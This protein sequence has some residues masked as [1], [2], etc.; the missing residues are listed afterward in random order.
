MDDDLTLNPVLTCYRCT[1]ANI[2]ANSEANHGCYCWSVFP[3]RTGDRQ[4]KGHHS[5]VSGHQSATTKW[6]HNLLER[7]KK[8]IFLKAGE[9]GAA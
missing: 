1:E 9:P 2:E 4:Q 3:A 6:G 8:P 5:C 7:I